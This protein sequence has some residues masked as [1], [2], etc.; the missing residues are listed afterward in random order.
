M[1]HKRLTKEEKHW[2]AEV[3]A[4]TLASANEIRSD[5]ARMGAAKKIAA[6]EAQELQKRT[7]AMQTVARAKPPTAPKPARKAAKKTTARKAAKKTTA[8]RKR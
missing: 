3:D 5:K 7:R 2:R 4:N 8:R 6:T 1:G